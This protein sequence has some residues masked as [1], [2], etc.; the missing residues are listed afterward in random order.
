MDKLWKG[1]AIASIWA[2]SAYIIVNAKD[3]E[4]IPVIFFFATLATVFTANGG[5]V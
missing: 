1:I 4:Y 5:K 3:N 2:A